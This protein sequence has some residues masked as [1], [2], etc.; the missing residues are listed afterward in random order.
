MNM[1]YIPPYTFYTLLVD[2]EMFI[3]NN[4]KMIFVIHFSAALY[5]M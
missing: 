4:C 5:G 3:Y 2:M 1:G